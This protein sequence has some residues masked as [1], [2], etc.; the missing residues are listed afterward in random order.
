MFRSN[1]LYCSGRW[2]AEQGINLWGCET[3]NIIIIILIG[4]ESFSLV[5]LAFSGSYRYGVA[6]LLDS[7]FQLLPLQF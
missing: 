2:T 6:E 1:K 4:S 5:N 7:L 3:N